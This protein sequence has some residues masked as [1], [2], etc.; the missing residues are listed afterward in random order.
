MV[1][2]IQCVKITKSAINDIWRCYLALLF[3]E[4]W[5]RAS[6]VINEAIMLVCY[7]S[8]FECTNRSPVYSADEND[9]GKLS[10]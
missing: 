4:N 3:G 2:V 9:E 5:G 1:I 6:F 8:I 7:R 10:A